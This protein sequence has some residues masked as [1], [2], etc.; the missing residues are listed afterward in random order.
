MTEL[1]GVTIYFNDGS[2]MLVEYSKQE[3]DEYNMVTKMKEILENKHFL[4]EANGALVYIPVDNIKYMQVY[5]CPE[6]LPSYTIRGASI[7][8]T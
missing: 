1:R 4:I 5:P 8:D 2:K 3:Q 7:I 6:K